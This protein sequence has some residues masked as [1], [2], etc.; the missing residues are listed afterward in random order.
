MQRAAAT[1]RW[2]GSWHTVFVTADRVGG[3]PVDDAFETELRGHLEPF[4]MAGY[5]LEVDGP[6]FVPLDVE[7]HVCVQPDYFRAHVNG[8]CARRPLEPRVRRRDARLLPPR[9]LH[10]RRAGLP[11]RDRRRRRRA[12][13]ASSR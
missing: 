9:P 1:F 3:L 2:T 5:D 13:R 6:R 8:R 4:R 7:L 10:V 11:L 12:S